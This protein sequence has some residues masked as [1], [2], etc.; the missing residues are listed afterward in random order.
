[1]DGANYHPLQAGHRIGGGS[2]FSR[3]W[4]CRL[5]GRATIVSF[6][7][8]KHQTKSQTSVTLQRLMQVQDLQSLSADCA[9]KPCGLFGGMLHGK[10]V[11]LLIRACR[12][13]VRGAHS[14]CRTCG[15][16]AL[17]IS[18]EEAQACTSIP[19]FP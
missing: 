3:G 7:V 8:Q 9:P 15:W 17:G 13:V 6:S 4:L 12:A 1:M 18:S 14:R 16:G 19:V 11:L 2:V 10:R 5:R